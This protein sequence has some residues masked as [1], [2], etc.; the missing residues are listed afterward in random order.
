MR[1]DRE[2]ETVE[3]RCLDLRRMSE[4]ISREGESQLKQKII[5]C[6][7]CGTLTRML[8]TKSCDNCWEMAAR[9]RTTNFETLA[10]ILAE[11]QPT[12]KLSPAS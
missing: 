3:G 11:N 2:F 7:Y 5:P 6:K 10:K 8:G 12:W 1:N 4:W 9:I